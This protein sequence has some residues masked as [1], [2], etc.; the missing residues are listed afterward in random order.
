[1]TSPMYSQSI[2]CR[3]RNHLIDNI[4]NSWSLIAAGVLNQSGIWEHLGSAGMALGSGVR[5]LGFRGREG[6][7]EGR[8]GL[9]VVDQ[10][11][12]YKA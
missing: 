4:W 2:H 8:W 3:I 1:M 7:L 11:C 5:G 10:L 6:H 9:P 12:L